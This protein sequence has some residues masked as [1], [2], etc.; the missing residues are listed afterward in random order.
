MIALLACGASR[1]EI[2]ALL[3]RGGGELVLGV[4]NCI[5]RCSGRP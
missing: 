2:R 1:D 4:W 5:G 3:N